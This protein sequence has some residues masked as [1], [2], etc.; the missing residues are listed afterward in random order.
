M[1][2]NKLITNQFKRDYSR[3]RPDVAAYKA[4]LDDTMDYL[5][6]A[7]SCIKGNIKFRRVLQNIKFNISELK[8]EDIEL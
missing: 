7:I 3:D 4:H 5:D 8:M 6:E 1:S 2:S